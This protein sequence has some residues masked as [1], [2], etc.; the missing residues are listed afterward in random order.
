MCSI[1]KQ[2]YCLEQEIEDFI[3]CYTVLLITQ[4]LE[5]YKQN[6]YKKNKKGWGQFRFISQSF[7]SLHVYG[8]FTKMPGMGHSVQILYDI[9][10]EV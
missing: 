1:P 8:N 2:G 5:Q 7:V 9:G 10:C 6:I 3:R 4:L